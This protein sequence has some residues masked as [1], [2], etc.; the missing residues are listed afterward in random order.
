MVS[1]FEAKLVSK[2]WLTGD[3]ILLSFDTPGDF[4]FK[5][6]QFV[7]IILKSGEV[8]KARPYS[9]LNPPSKRGKLDLCI[10][11]VEDGFASVIFKQMKLGDT[12]MA[13]GP[14]GHFLFDDVTKND[15]WFVGGGTGIAPL[16]SMVKEFLS[17]NPSKQ[18]CLIVGYKTS[19]DLLFHEE[20]LTLRSKYENFKYIPVLSRDTWNG[21]VG[22][23]QDHLGADLQ[24]KTFYICGLKE[25]VMET[26]ELLLNYGVK[27][28]NIRFERY[29]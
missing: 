10:K 29:T 26:K 1:S 23:V 16:Y 12:V 8:Q 25:L 6:G 19:K 22:H 15:H 5:A 14:L 21:K 7:S 24:N 11:I 3:V 18:F 27:P 9:I 13:K 20:L 17:K 4:S 2:K 28:E